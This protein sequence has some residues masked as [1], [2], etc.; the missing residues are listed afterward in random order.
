VDPIV[1]GGLAKV[2]D[3][4][5]NESAK[6]AGNLLIRLLGP[7]AD[8]YGEQLRQIV[9]RQRTARA[10][11]LLTK[12]EAKSRGRGGSVPPRVAFRV[13]E[14]GTLSDD[15][16]MAEYLSGVLAGS[17]TPDGRDDRAVPWSDLLTRMSSLQLRAHYVLYRE[18]ASGLSGR[19]DINLGNGPG[20]HHARLVLDMNEFASAVHNEGDALSA[21]ETVTHV[22]WGLDQHGLI[23]DFKYGHGSKVEYDESTDEMMKRINLVERGEPEPEIFRP[24][25]EYVFYGSPTVLGVEL[26]GWAAGISG[27]GVGRF[28]RCAPTITTDPPIPPLASALFPS[29]PGRNQRTR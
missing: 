15:E 19:D 11:R 21:E 23:T 22:L 8:E 17:R 26:W 9:A 1:A 2:A 12:A 18:W 25:Y 16:L 5:A 6:I 28:V 3:A 29:M 10:E 7:A 24:P 27:L 4:N 20:R 13:L 14:D